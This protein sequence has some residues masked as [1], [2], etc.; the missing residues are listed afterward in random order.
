MHKR[1]INSF[2]A[3]GKYLDVNRT[4]TIS[5]L[6]PVILGVF[7]QMTYKLY[8]DTLRAFFKTFSE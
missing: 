2:K 6:F 5:V 3:T 8:A 1:E 4:T 7:A